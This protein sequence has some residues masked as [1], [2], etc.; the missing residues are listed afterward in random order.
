[1]IKEEI[2]YRLAEAFMKES[3]KNGQYLFSMRTVDK[4]KWWVHFERTAGYRS[5]KGWTPETH[6]KCCFEKHGP[7]LPFRLFGKTAL[8]AWE[9]YHHRFDD[10]N[11]NDFVVQML[12]TY[13]KMKKIYGEY[14]P[15]FYKANQ[16]FIRRGNYSIH[17][18]SLSKSFRELNDKMFFYD[19]DVLD[20]KRIVV[21]T[22]KKVYKTMES[23]FGDDFYKGK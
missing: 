9:E 14:N 7:I 1:M 20:M 2:S 5:I 3:K 22:N 11:K 21:Y 6:V 19:E 15:E 8:E 23:L 17:F 10:V 12:N 4:S 16:L 18:L 13:K